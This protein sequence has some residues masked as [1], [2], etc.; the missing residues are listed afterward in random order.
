MKNLKLRLLSKLQ[1]KYVNVRKM[2]PLSVKIWDRL[3][4]PFLMNTILSQGRVTNLAWR[5][6]ISYRFIQWLLSY[7]RH[8]GAEA[9]VKWLK[10]SLVAL[11]KGLGNDRMSSL[12]PL[13]TAL[14]Y[15]RLSG[16]NLSRIIPRQCR[17]RI[18]KLDVKEIRF[19]TGLFNLYRVLQIP[20]ILKLETIT[21]PFTGHILNME[22]YFSLVKQRN[23]FA[24]LEGFDVVRQRSLVPKKF[25][26][27]MAASPSSKVSALGI[28]TDIYLLNKFRPDL[29]QEMLYYLHAVGCKADGEIL[30]LMDTGYHLITQIVEWNGKEIIG[31]SGN[32]YFQSDFLQLKNSLRAHG[33]AASEGEGLSQ[34]AIKDEAA[35]KA[36]LFALIDSVTQS[37]LAPLH[38]YLFALLRVIP[39]DGTF[40]QEASVRRSSKKAIMTGQAF[41]FD[42]TAATDR[43]PA[44]LTAVILDSVTGK[45]ISE[46]W[47]R[48][49]T[50]RNFFFNGQ[51]AERKGIPAGPYRYA[52]GQPMGGLSSWAGLAIT[53][54]WIVQVAAI[55]ANKGHSWYLNYEIL[56]DDL[57]IFEADVAKEYLKIM[58]DLGCEINLTKSIQSPNRPVFEFAKRTVVAS[59]IVSGISIAQVWAGWKVSGRVAN[60]LSFINTGLITSPTLLALSLTRSMLI[61]GALATKEIFTKSSRSAANAL[62]IG[63]LSLLG[64]AHSK[65]LLSLSGVMTALVNPHNSEAD[66]SDEAVGLP[67][68]ASLNVNYDIFVKSQI[69]DPLWSNM[70]ART[71]VYDE[72]K[73]ELATVI[74]QT[75]LK[76]AKLLY[77][78][79]DKYVH[80]FAMGLIVGPHNLTDPK[81]GVLRTDL[82]SEL[83]L[84]MIQLHNYAEWLLG[85]QM[86]SEHPEDIY[87]SL[88]DLAYKHAKSH[89]RLVSHKDALAWLDKVE[90]LEFKLKLPEKVVPGK[91]V[92]ETAPILGFLRNMDPNRN[93]KATYTQMPR[94]TEYLTV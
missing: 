32:K 67:L 37:I 29:W 30:K 85:L 14:A 54:H 15:S 61:N 22:F 2:M 10:A 80:K 68:V 33:L 64:I 72:Y 62:S 26:L 16:G 81:E 55:N 90:Q 77:E 59:Q 39:N 40:D 94:F 88:Y 52:V 31:K 49:M 75:A 50:D 69:P 13:G 1:T 38:D 11:Q 53:H 12:Q 41:S 87:E 23:L 91:T 79:V 56:G 44:A 63:S 51:V 36:R 86:T 20:S 76:R 47:L 74:L 93:V 78:N 89:D 6:K 92:H 18:R 73:Y 25:T 8:H 57:V 7:Q 48:L 3:L 65:E 83:R 43:L 21:A 9:T 17:G 70:D 66:F 4:R 82:P 71:E 27:S 46:S 19:W 42:L 5:M 34:F 45:E 35:G 24:L 28:L 84:L 60:A 58:A